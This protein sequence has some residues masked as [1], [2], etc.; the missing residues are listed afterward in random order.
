MST[1]IAGR[2]QTQ[3]DVAFAID[4]L[5]R[6]GFRRAAISSFYVNPAGQ[7]DLYVNDS[8]ED[9]PKDAKESRHGM[10]EGASVGG[11]LGIAAGAATLPLTGPA[12]P[13]VGGLVGGYIGSL[14]GC[15]HAMKERSE[16]EE[17]AE[18]REPE[19]KAGMMVAVAAENRQQ[20]TDALDLLKAIHANAIEC[21]PGTIIDGDWSD[22]D[23]LSTAHLRH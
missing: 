7:H 18:P 6:I 9:Q 2:F 10:A 22:F 15:L 13:I 16:A 14:V 3:S 17:S 4:E 11:I 8:V 1:I 19:R 20:E 12:A 21:C 5:E 23:P